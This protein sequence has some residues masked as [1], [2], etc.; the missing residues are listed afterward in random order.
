MTN[1]IYV[2][3]TREPQCAG[4]KIPGLCDKCGFCMAGEE[5]AVMRLAPDTILAGF[6][7]RR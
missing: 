5:D 6:K 7:L 3:G 4:Y 2:D 1:F